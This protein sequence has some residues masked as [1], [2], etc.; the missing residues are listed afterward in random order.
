MTRS[1]VMAPAT[2][3]SLVEPVREAARPGEALELLLA[4][5]V[6]RTGAAAGWVLDAKGAAR[7]SAGPAADDAPDGQLR[8]PLRSRGEELGTL[9]LRFSGEAP[10]PPPDA[11]SVAVVAALLLDNERLAE[12][13]RVADQSREHFLVALNHELRTPAT[14]LVLVADLLRSAQPGEFPEL[15]VEWLGHAE[16]HVERIMKVLEGL[17]EATAA[18]NAPSEADLVEPRQLAADALRRVEPA[19]RR[20]GLRLSL[21]FP[22]DLPLLQTDAHRCSRILL[23]LLDNAV[24][25]S[26]AGEVRVRLDRLSRAQGG[27]PG[28]ALRLSV[29]DAGCGIPPDQLER[30]FEPFAQVEE[31][32]RNVE[33]G[34]GAGLGLTIARRLARSLGGDLVLAS[35]ERGTTATLTVP[36]ARR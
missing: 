31:G 16:K 10:P 35:D 29:H 32:A 1:P 24:H 12:E 6:E 3:G 15:L 13:A 9:L 4:S 22:P 33:M 36:Y 25:F 21:S 27:G 2:W 30:V 11:A 28:G 34:R 18:L 14:G 7:T 23:H 26:D 17:L 19:A 5:L 8:L 20:K